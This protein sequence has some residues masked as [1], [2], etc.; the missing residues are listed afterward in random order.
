MR[1]TE[2]KKKPTDVENDEKERA[3]GDDPKW[4]YLRLN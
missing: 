2:A 3:V 1:E 4:K